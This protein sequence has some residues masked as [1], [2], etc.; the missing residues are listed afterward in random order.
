MGITRIRL[1]K[2]MKEKAVE[3]FGLIE[4]LMDVSLLDE[5]AVYEKTLEDRICEVC[6]Y[7]LNDT[8]LSEQDRQQYD[9]LLND[10]FSAPFIKY[11]ESG[12]DSV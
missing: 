4:G 8:P 7:V 3:V 2:E 10:F 6:E 1:E 11:W 9:T 12:C 5:E